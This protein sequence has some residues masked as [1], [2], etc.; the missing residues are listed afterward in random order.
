MWQ[1]HVVPHC[2][3]QYSQL[4]DA[5]RVSDGRPVMLKRVSKSVHPYEA[6]LALS[7]SAD[8]MSSKPDNH[9]VPIFDVLQSPEEDD[10]QIFVM[11]FLRPIDNPRFDTFGEA[12]S[13][14]DQVFRVSTFPLPPRTA[15]PDG[16]HGKGL[17]FLHQHNVAHRYLSSFMSFFIH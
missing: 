8:H 4:V 7:Y 15:R 6:E 11:S 5:I 10:A 17:A 3:T 1:L 2:D 14:F 16:P 9:V 13:F 12:I